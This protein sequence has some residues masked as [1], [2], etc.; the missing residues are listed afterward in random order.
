ML[1]LSALGCLQE[2]PVFDATRLVPGLGALTTLTPEQ[3]VVYAALAESQPSH[4]VRAAVQRLLRR[5]AGRRF[6][7]WPLIRPLI[8]GVRAAR[9]R[10]FRTD[11]TKR[12]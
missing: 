5:T 7:R 3:R 1:G 6:H 2:F 11:T 8:G 12:G 9:R 4:D 10:F